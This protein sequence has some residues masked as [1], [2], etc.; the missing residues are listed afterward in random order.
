MFDPTPNNKAH[1]IAAVCRHLASGDA[2]DAATV[3]RAQYPFV[4]TAKQQRRYT[5]RTMARIFL[6]DGFVDRYSGERLV[7][8][9]TLRLLSKL[10]PTE[11]PAHPNWKVS[12]S[13]LVYWELFPRSTTCCPWPAVVLMTRATGSR[14]QC[15]ETLRRRTGRWMSWHGNCSLPGR[16][17]TGTG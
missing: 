17:K 11:F 4:A 6:R 7:F 3:A 2:A 13:H 16:F 14:R 9:G 1:V 12:E 10:M 15:F 8:P 5:E